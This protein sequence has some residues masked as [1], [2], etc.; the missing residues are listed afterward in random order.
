MGL[1]LALFFIFHLQKDLKDGFFLNKKCLKQEK[2]ENASAFV[3]SF[4]FLTA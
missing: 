4:D 2:N 1:A 3:I